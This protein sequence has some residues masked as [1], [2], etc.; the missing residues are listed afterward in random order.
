[1]LMVT[2]TGSSGLPFQSQKISRLLKTSSA[3]IGGSMV[4]E[5][6]GEQEEVQARKR[7]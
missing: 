6:R 3:E 2:P 1:M 4:L 7:R 5:E